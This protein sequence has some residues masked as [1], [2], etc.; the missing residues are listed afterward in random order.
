MTT[1]QNLPL[2]D[3]YQPQSV[4]IK[5]DLENLTQRFFLTTAASLAEKLPQRRYALNLCRDRYFFSLGFCAALM[6]GATTLLPP[7]RQPQTIAEMSANYEDCYCLTDTAVEDRQVL[8]RCGN[9]PLIDIAQNHDIDC[10]PEGEMDV[11]LIAGE[12]LAAIAFTSGSTG[13]PKP[14]KKPWF[15]LVGTAQMLAQRF[16][17]ADFYSVKGRNGQMSRPTIIATVPSQ[18]MY[19]LEMTVMMALQGGVVMHNSHPFYPRDV[20]ANLDSVVADPRVLV[21]T[22]VHLRAIVGSGVVVPPL[23][24]IIS[25][26]APLDMELAR[27][28]EQRFEA[29]VEEIFG[30]TEAGSMATRRTCS[31]A[32]ESEW[33]L[34]EGMDMF[35]SGQ[36]YSVTGPQLKGEKRLEDCFEPT[37]ENSFRLL[38]RATDQI[39]VAGKRASLG[40]LTQRLLNISGVED[41]IVFVNDGAERPAALV[42][43][44]LP[45][46]QILNVLSKTVDAVFLPRPL[47]KVKQIPRNET[48]KITRALVLKALKE[49]R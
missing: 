31:N 4:L 16:F 28:A 23:A 10:C 40:D 7:N 41:A 39:N 26:T 19:G 49:N 11:P 29:P 33:V 1:P 2:I 13:K 12:Q 17:N 27:R 36:G 32:N 20:A 9:L 48:G 42:V 44:A 46:R 21:T 34:L 47:K 45:A 15:T 30:C 6:R 35:A 22:P 24:K 37:G 5:R 14:N 43:S 3:P 8:S 38:G 18:H 25:A